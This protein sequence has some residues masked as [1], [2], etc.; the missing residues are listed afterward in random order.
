LERDGE[1]VLGGTIAPPVATDPVG[2]FGSRNVGS[3]SITVF[4]GIDLIADQGDPTPVTGLLDLTGSIT[5]G[6]R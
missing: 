6:G 1:N 5:N 2:F 4:Q 3:E